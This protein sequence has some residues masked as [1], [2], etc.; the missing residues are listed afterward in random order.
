M[1]AMRRKRKGKIKLYILFLLLMVCSFIFYENKKFQD[2]IENIYFQKKLAGE[3][4]EKTSIKNIFL[5]NNENKYTLYLINFDGSE[6]KIEDLKSVGNINFSIPILIQK[7]NYGYI[8]RNGEVIIPLEYTKATNF[9]DGI[10]VV[11]KEKYGVIDEKGEVLLPFEYE[12]IFLG[13][14]KRV[15]LKKD[16]VYYASNL[17]SAQIIDVDEITEITSGQ[18]FFKKGNEYGIMDIYG[19]FLAKSNNFNKKDFHLNNYPKI[20]KNRR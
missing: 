15:I 14:K 3:N 4:I 5:I 9:K 2:R 19:N 11:M 8:N 7:D 13:E 18:L 12:E 6:K 17:K 16:G 10:A 20:N 1:I